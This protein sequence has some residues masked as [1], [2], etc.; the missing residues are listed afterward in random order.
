MAKLR[1]IAE[2]VEADLP[3]PD[4]VLDPWLP[5]QGLAMIAGPTGSGKT[6]LMM[7]CAIAIAGGGE[8]IGWK[9]KQPRR[10]LYVDGEMA[11]RDIQV[12]ART[13]LEGLGLSL[14]QVADRLTFLCSVDQEAGLGSLSRPEVR[15]MIMNE[16]LKTN[17]EVLVLDNLSCLLNSDDENDAGSWVDIQ[18]WLLSLRRKGYTVVF[19]HHTGKAQK[20]AKGHDWWVQRGTSKREDVLNTS[21]LIKPLK[22]AHGTKHD[23]WIIF[24]K[25]RGFPGDSLSVTMDVS[26]DHCTFDLNTI[27]EQK[28][29]KIMGGIE[30]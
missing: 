10:V 15:T 22:T 11:L 14:V 6:M 16:L 24:P 4:M 29:E 12:R 1:T 25:H 17:S 2:L 20:D 23:L 30:T 19:L 13:I 9:A 28:A 21:V 5:A 26:E 3:E 7:A 8:M 18:K 27:P